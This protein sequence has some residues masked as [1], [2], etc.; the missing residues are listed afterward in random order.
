MIKDFNLAPQLAEQLIKHESLFL[1]GNVSA[2]AAGAWL[3]YQPLNETGQYESCFFIMSLPFRRLNATQIMFCIDV[4]LNVHR[5]NCF[6]Y[7][8]RSE[9]TTALLR[10]LLLCF[11][12]CDTFNI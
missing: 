5:R 11:V 1:S 8:V 7:T 9:A 12:K 2:A 4:S 3:I 10:Y 6:P